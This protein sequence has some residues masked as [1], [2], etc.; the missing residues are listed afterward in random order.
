MPPDHFLAR[1]VEQRRGGDVPR[2]AVNAFERAVEEAIA[3]AH[4][5]AA[6]ADLVE[7]GVERSG[8]DLMQQRLPDMREV[9]IDQDDVVLF[10]AVFAAEPPHQ[11]E[12]AS[13]SAHH[14]NLRLLVAHAGPLNS[15]KQS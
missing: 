14:D 5:M 3:P 12:P 2:G 4:G 1:I 11:L 15:V 7:I 8:G 6:I 13:A 10:A 9:A